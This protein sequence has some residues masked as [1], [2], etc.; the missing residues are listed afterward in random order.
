MCRGTGPW[1]V[2]SGRRRTL[3]GNVTAQ[4][5]MAVLLKDTLPD[6]LAARLSMAACFGCRLGFGALLADGIEVT[7]WRADW[8]CEVG[9]DVDAE[10]FNFGC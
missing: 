3:P 5:P 8:R 2:L 9:C 1:L 4:L 10:Q 6:D 7:R